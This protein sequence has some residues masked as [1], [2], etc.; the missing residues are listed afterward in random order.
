MGDV[1]AIAALGEAGQHTG[2]MRRAMTALTGRHHLVFVF[3]TGNTGNALMFGF[4][5]AVQF[6]GLLVAR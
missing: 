5:F 1:V 4:G 2:R 6:K 3:V